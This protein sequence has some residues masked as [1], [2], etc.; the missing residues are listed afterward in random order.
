MTDEYHL[1]FETR[2]PVDLKKFGVYAYAAHPEARVLCAAIAKNDGPVLTWVDP[3]IALPVDWSEQEEAAELLHEISRREKPIRVWAHNAQFEFVVWN[4]ILAPWGLKPLNIQ[5]MNCTASL[6]RRA[7]IPA[8]LDQAARFLDL[9]AQKDRRG[10]ALI[11]KF[12]I[13]DKNTGEF[14][15]IDRENPG[16]D[17]SDLVGYCR[18]DVEV[19]RQLHRALKAFDRRANRAI[20][21]FNFRVNEIGFPV[22]KLALEAAEKVILEDREK[23]TVRFREITGGLNPTQRDKCLLWLKENGFTGLD[24]TRP[25]VEEEINFADLRGVP[26]K[27]VEALRL[28]QLISYA[29]LKK[30]PVMRDLADEDLRVRGTLLDHGAS[31]GR[32][33]SKLV[34]Q[35]NLKR[36][37]K[38]SELFY[39]HFCE[40]PHNWTRDGVL[41]I[42]GEPAEVF[43]GAIRHFIQPPEGASLVAAD[44][45]AIECRVVNWLAGQHDALREFRE[46]MDRYIIMASHIYDVP[47]KRISKDGIERFLGKQAVLGCGYQMGASKFQA[48]CAGYGVEIHAHL[49]EKAVKTYR[50][51]HDKVVTFWWDIEKAVRRAILHPGERFDCRKVS[52]FCAKVAGKKFLFIELP[53]GRLLSY[54]EP[55]VDDR[56]ISFWGQLPG[57]TQWGRNST[58]GGKLVENITQAVSADIMIHGGNIAL[59][60]GHEICMMVHDEAVKYVHPGEDPRQDHFV[61]CLTTLPPWAEGLPLV[62]EAK[63]LP[64]Y[65]K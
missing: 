39:H 3:D 47:A 64:F 59:N 43:S 49:A 14:H 8:S 4:R 29:A 25:T 42:F 2:S 18:Q 33:S 53:S 27:T 48:T 54:P 55:Q 35:Q 6:A 38:E 7:V 24:L 15:S 5:D 19:E 36:S 40:A 16:Q 32:S 62:A 10:A 23:L 51:Q 34:Q 46:G 13:P 37:T 63:T 22:N 31:T 11:R 45:A 12:C 65:T 26:E 50:A 20:F 56:E 28:R 41:A 30:I 58:Y 9:G 57:S 60:E 1:D 21:D 52:A 17:F 61:E 44:Y